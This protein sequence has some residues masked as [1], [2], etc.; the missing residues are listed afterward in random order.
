MLTRIEARFWGKVE[1][2]SADVCWI[3]RGTLVRGGY[4]QFSVRPG[5]RCAAHRF[6]W[7][8]SNGAIP[9]GLFACHRCDNPPCVN[10]AHL[11][12]GT[13]KDNMQDKVAKGR[14]TNQYVGQ[15]HCKRGHEYSAENTRVDSR[16][17]RICRACRRA[18]SRTTCLA[19]DAS[20]VV[21]GAL[22]A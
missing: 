12:L 17:V 7:E 10:P 18:G 16:G 9:D 14:H 2:Q 4:G 15:T 1:R 22:P 21:K 8:L 3:W 6:A 20:L 11:F 5:Q 13:P 19:T